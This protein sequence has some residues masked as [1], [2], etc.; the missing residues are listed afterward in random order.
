MGPGSA[1]D[2]RP[3]A[4]ESRLRRGRRRSS[5]RLRIAGHAARDA[6]AADPYAVRFVERGTDLVLQNEWFEIDRVIHMDGRESAGNPSLHSARVF[7][8]HVGRRNA[9]NHDDAHRPADFELYGLSACR[10]VVRCESSSASRRATAAR[11]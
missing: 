1:A 4:K 9:G 2:R 8:W 7:G 5:A 10:G 11:R 6:V 3:R